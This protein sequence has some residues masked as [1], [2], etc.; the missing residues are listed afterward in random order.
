[1]GRVLPGVPPFDRIG[2]LRFELLL[3]QTEESKTSFSL[4]SCSTGQSAKKLYFQFNPKYW[5]FLASYG[6]KV[7]HGIG[8]VT[9]IYVDV[10]QFFDLVALCS[11]S[12]IDAVEKDSLN[13]LQI[14][15]RFFQFAIQLRYNI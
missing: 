13:Q 14:M 11:Q 12:M 3:R 7:F 6:K 15:N 2:V 10:K 4:V 1:M 9:K 8:I 5:D